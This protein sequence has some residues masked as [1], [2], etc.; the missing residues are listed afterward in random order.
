SD[1]G[2]Y[3]RAPVSTMTLGG[4]GSG[5]LSTLAPQRLLMLRDA[6]HTDAE[7]Y[8]ARTGQQPAKHVARIVCAQVHSAHANADDER[9]S[10]ACNDSAPRIAEAFRDEQRIENRRDADHAHHRVS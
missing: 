8:P 3:R 9:H 4:R 2:C 5:V 7:A 6:A 10:E 1:F